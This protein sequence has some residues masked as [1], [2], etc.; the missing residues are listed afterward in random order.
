MSLGLQIYYLVVVVSFLCWKGLAYSAI[1]LP[2]THSVFCFP[3]FAAWVTLLRTNLM[4]GLPFS[5]KNYYRFTNNVSPNN[6]M[7]TGQT[8]EVLTPVNVTTLGSAS[9][10]NWQL[11]SQAGLYFIRNY[12]GGAQL[13]LGVTKD[14]L[15]V[16]R[17]L[18]RAGDLGQQWLISRREDGSWRL[19]N[20]L[21]GNGSSLSLSV[22]NTIPGMDPSEAYGHWEISV[23]LSAGDITDQQM[24]TDVDNVEVS[25]VYVPSW[26]EGKLTIYSRK[27]LRRLPSHPWPQ[28]PHLQQHLLI[29]QIAPSSHRLR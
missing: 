12:N 13:Q 23:N 28:I 25:D 16:P 14:S 19:A 26:R 29:P 21:V 4:S 3:S 1:C 27:R 8:Y 10:E 20:G 11:Y 9:S 6:S 22:G 5:S 17:M 24:L 2:F 7:S 15:I 18:P